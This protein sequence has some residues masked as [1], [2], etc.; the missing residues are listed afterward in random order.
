MDM[1]AI[2]VLY[3]IS[4]D[5]CSQSCWFLYSA[6]KQQVWIV[7]CSCP[8]LLIKCMAKYIHEINYKQASL[9]FNIYK[10]AF[11]LIPLKCKDCAAHHSPLPL[12]ETQ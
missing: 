6:S 8:I 2:Y 9:T 11:Q 12:L 1:V 10:K 7:L 4:Y 3:V 5:F